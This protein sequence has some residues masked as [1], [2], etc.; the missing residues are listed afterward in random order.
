VKTAEAM[1]RLGFINEVPNRNKLA[2]YY[3][4][5]FCLEPPGSLPTTSDATS[6]P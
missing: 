1:K 2:A 4:F 3:D 6:K 5:S